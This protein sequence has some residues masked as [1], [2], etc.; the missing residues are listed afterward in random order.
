M[1]RLPSF[2]LIY[3]KDWYFKSHGDVVERMH[4]SSEYK[5]IHGTLDGALIG[6]S[7]SSFASE[8]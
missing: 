6:S 1:T 5:A 2:E 8:H 7:K 4:R 3:P